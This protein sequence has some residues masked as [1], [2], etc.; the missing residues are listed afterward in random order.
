M[1]DEDDEEEDYEDEEED[2]DDD[3]DAAKDR[4]AFEVDLLLLLPSVDEHLAA[5][6][7]EASEKEAL[8]RGFQG[9]D[10]RAV[11]EEVRCPGESG[12]EEAALR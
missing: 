6:F 1:G 7:R 2:D 9:L 11:E 10:F 3:D 8:R 4:L 12:R 5:S